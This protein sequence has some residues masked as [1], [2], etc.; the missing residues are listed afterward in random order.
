MCHGFAFTPPLLNWALRPRFLFHL[1]LLS[2]SSFASLHT[3]DLNFGFI[4]FRFW[5]SLYAIYSALA[6]CPG[7]G[8]FWFEIGSLIWFTDRIRIGLIY[9]RSKRV[10]VF[11]C[12]DPVLYRYRYN[13]LWLKKIN[14][15]FLTFNLILIEKKIIC[16][17][18]NVLNIIKHIFDWISKLYKIYL[19]I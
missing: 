4:P 10:P 5:K 11:Y 8:Q 13:F 3:P 2:S 9:D 7:Q 1:H 16:K 14:K 19:F 18:I 15:I 12:S 6:L 17:E